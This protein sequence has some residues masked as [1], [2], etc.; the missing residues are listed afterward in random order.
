M[1]QSCKVICSCIS[2]KRRGTCVGD[3]FGSGLFT[4][5]LYHNVIDSSKDFKAD[6]CLTRGNVYLRDMVIMC[7]LGI[8]MCNT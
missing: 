3:P 5:Y 1:C 2:E 6:I 7:A 8:L 4:F